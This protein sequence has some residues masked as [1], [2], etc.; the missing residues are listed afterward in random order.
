M[1]CDENGNDKYIQRIPLLTIIKQPFS[2][3]VG[4]ISCIII[5]HLT[6]NQYK[7]RISYRRYVGLT[8][9]TFHRKYVYCTYSRLL[10][11]ILLITSYV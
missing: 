2:P 5:V 1:F 4:F 10:Y 8:D 7:L 9:S 11:S 6:C 3:N